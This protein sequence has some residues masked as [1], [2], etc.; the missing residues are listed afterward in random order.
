MSTSPASNTSRSRAANAPG[1]GGADSGM[2]RSSPSVR[3]ITSSQ[4][5]PVT[6]SIIAAVVALWARARREPRVP[7]F[8]TRRSAG[9]GAFTAA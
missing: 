2:D 1:R 9:S 8:S 5:S 4:L 6:C 7:I 3:T